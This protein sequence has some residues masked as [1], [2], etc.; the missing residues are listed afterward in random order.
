M[1][2][3][4]KKTFYILVFC[5]NVGWWTTLPQ[6]ALA[7]IGGSGTTNYVT[8]WLDSSNLTN[9]IMYDS[10]SAIGVGT[11][12]PGA[13]LTVNGS[14]FLLGGDVIDG[15]YDSEDRVFEIQAYDGAAYLNL[16]GKNGGFV[17]ASTDYGEG[18]NGFYSS[19]WPMVFYT[20]GENDA[21]SQERMRLTN[22]GKIGIGTASP[23]HLLDLQSSGSVS[24]PTLRVKATSGNGIARLILDSHDNEWSYIR[25]ANNGTTTWDTGTYAGADSWQI[26]ENGNTPSVVVQ[27]GGNVGIGTTEPG[28]KLTVSQDKTE[29]GET[30]NHLRLQGATDPNKMLSLGFHTTDNVGFIQSVQYGTAAKPLALQP[31]G[32]NVGIGTTAPGSQL[33]VFSEINDGIKITDGI[34]TGIMFSSATLTNSLAIGTQSNHP[35]IFGTNNVF[36]QL[37]IQNET[38]NIGIGTD[39]P[40]APMEI[41]KDIDFVNV[42][43]YAQLSVRPESGDTGKMLNI[44]YDQD[45]DIGF[46]QSLNRGVDV[47][48]LV[49]QRY[50]GNVGIGTTTPTQ[51]LDVNGYVKGTGVCIGTDCRTTWPTSSSGDITGSGTTNYLPKWTGSSSVGNSIVY[52]SGS[53]VGIGTTSPSQKLHVVGRSLFSATSSST[54]MVVENL[55]SGGGLYIDTV[56]SQALEIDTDTGTGVDVY[57]DSG[58]AVKATSIS[59]L[60]GDF[61]GDVYVADELSVGSLEVRGGDIC[62]GQCD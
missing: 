1:L 28:G 56:G 20:G 58:T 35:L 45:V 25:Y 8:K 9:S 30:T 21:Q 42:D 32:G 19:Q 40:N 13:T 57:T 43:T 54:A 62:L 38:G 16:K 55:S 39:A 61:K 51:K 59:G 36:P 47:T 6:A 5:L 4:M 41:V 33:A 50:G 52:D 44:A 18:S 24:T 29:Y 3:D 31:N 34:T 7:V 37:M 22:D 46:I 53:S 49:L 23:E 48:P 17:L 10:G 12:N 26:R 60:A 2:K 27:P 14:S 11:I 15:I